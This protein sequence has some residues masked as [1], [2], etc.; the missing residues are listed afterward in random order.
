MI[1]K[2]KGEFSFEELPI[3]GSLKLK[4]T[5]IGFTELNQPI[6]FQMKMPA[7]GG[8]TAMAGDQGQAMGG[9]SAFDKDLG[10]IKLKAAVNQ[11]A[12]VTV[13]ATKPTLKMDIDKKVYNVEKDI[14]NAGGTAMDV[15]K[16]V[17]SVNVDDR[18]LEFIVRYSIEKQLHLGEDMGIISYNE[19]PLK[20]IVA[21][22]ITTIST[23]FARMG[24]SMATMIL[25]GKKEKIDNP[26]LLNLRNSF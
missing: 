26:F 11:L 6:S 7:A 1:T 15:M 5:A 10:N 17:P 14:V 19:A 16:N 2:T 4:I 18:D 13:T 23:D 3:M 24:K 9:M 12:E 21:S 20:G 8:A 25:D 22:G